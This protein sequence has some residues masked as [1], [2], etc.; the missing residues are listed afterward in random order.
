MARLPLHP[1]QSPPPAHLRGMSQIRPMQAG[2]Q[3]D[4][5]GMR[6]AHDGFPPRRGQVF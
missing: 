5:K 3:P 4:I 1:M 6:R 2:L